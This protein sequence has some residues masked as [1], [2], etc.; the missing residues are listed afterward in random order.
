[1]FFSTSASF[2]VSVFEIFCPLCL[3][4]KIIVGE[5]ILEIGTHPARS[6]V[7]FLSGVPSAMTEVV[8]ANLIPSSI[9]S[10]TLAGE[11]LPQS[12]VDALYGLPQMKRVF[13][14]YGPT[15]TTVYSTG[16]LRKAGG[17]P[18]L[19]RPL[20][21]ERV[22]VLDRNLQ[23]VPVGM[24]GELFIGGE[25]LARGYLNQPELTAQKFRTAPFLAGERIYKTGDGVRFKPDGTLEM[26]GRLDHQVKVRGFRVELG[27]IESAL[28]QIPDVTEAAVIARPDASNN[29]RLLG[30]VVR[31]QGAT[32]EPD[33]MRELLAKQLP[34]Y[35]VPSAIVSVEKFPLMANGKLDRA[36]LPEPDF[37]ARIEASATPRTLTEE[38]LVEMWC[39]V[40]GLKQL[41]INDDFF[42]V[43]GHSLLAA[44]V[45]ARMHAGFGI[46]ISLRQF[47]SASTVA[48]LALVVDDALIAEIKAAPDAG[49]PLLA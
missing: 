41:G 6:E 31:R 3:G 43:G 42:E 4:G 40:L 16:G 49:E 46:E 5:N 22:Y 9:T 13:D 24:P 34:E 27:E 45:L 44:Q 37:S 36:A 38:L 14:H 15:E 8:R 33:A 26:I 12:L 1:L 30:Y 35:M 47:F 23:P 20:A 21:N 29:S 28:R 10:V 32:M 2:D 19:G 48:R 7:T 39:D 17:A 25:K 18:S 11:L